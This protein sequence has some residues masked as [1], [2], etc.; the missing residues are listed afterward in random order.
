MV[1]P[2]HRNPRLG[3][4]WPRISRWGMMSPSPE[5][6]RPQP[7]RETWD[8]WREFTRG[9]VCGCGQGEKWLTL[10]LGLLLLESVL[11]SSVSV[12]QLTACGLC[13]QSAALG[14]TARPLALLRTAWWW[15]VEQPWAAGGVCEGRRSGCWACCVLRWLLWWGEGARWV[16][17][18][19]PPPPGT[20]EGRH[21]LRGCRGAGRGRAHS[22]SGR[23]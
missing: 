18:R 13:G 5:G 15:R 21:R 17:G 19:A 16:V 20:S 22:V 23:K 7:I 4:A 14:G 3:P 1:A 11:V 12:G 9:P 8:V 10:S 2:A 6:P